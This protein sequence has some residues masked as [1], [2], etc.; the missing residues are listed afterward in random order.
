MIPIDRARES[1]FLS[2]ARVILGHM[3]K[4]DNSKRSLIILDL[5]QCL[6]HVDM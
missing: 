6:R 5:F 3:L 2:T 1:R 4:L